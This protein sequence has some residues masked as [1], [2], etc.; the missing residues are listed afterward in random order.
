MRS[1]SYFKEAKKNVNKWLK[2]DGLEYKK[3]ISDV[4]YSPKNLFSPVEYR[5]DLGTS[6]ECNTYQV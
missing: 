2:E 3:K 4:N 6:M 5:P 1:D